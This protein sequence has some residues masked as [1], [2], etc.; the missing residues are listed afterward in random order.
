LSFI[1]YHLSNIDYLL[2][3]DQEMNKVILE[4]Q[5]TKTE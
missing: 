2:Q 1:Y 5:R 4:D 3:K